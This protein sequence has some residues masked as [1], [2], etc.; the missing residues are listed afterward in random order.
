M[1]TFLLHWAGREHQGQCS[2]ASQ[3]LQV[4]QSTSVTVVWTPHPLWQGRGRLSAIY[5]QTIWGS[6]P[7]LALCSSK[8]RWRE[9]QLLRVQKRPEEHTE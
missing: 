1:A 8:T 5:V 4:Y 9:A 7:P 6:L 3:S 2:S